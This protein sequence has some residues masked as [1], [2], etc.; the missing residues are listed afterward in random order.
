L[1]GVKPFTLGLYADLLRTITQRYHLDLTTCTLEELQSKLADIETGH[2][3]TYYRELVSCVKICL[4]HL[5]RR[6]LYDEIANPRLPNRAEIIKDKLLTD[7]EIR[8]LIRKAPSLADRLVIELFNET[9]ARRGEL[10]NL[11]IKSVQFDKYGAILTLTG[12]SGTRRR[13]VYNA[14]PDLRQYIN[15]HPNRKNPEAPLLLSRWNTPYHASGFYERIRLL[16]REILGRSIHP[17][18]FRHSTATRD[19]SMFT[20]REM[21]SLMGWSSAAMVGVYSHLSM[22]D[23]EN[24][25]LVLHGLKRK[26]ILRP[27]AGVQRCPKCRSDNAPIATYCQECGSVLSK[28]TGQLD[29]ESKQTIE[30][31]QAQIDEL[32]KGRG[33]A[34]ED[35]KALVEE[36][37]KTR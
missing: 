30:S 16:G 32:R 21:M 10:L 24:K 17:H 19:A 26:E 20:D 25:D 12:K 15:N 28:Q 34:K 27:I 7:Q 23:V 35:I 29:S 18:Q 6:D 11:K 31:M 5:K 9:G 37:L 8:Q 33:F 2:K 22:R 1:R 14:V 36:Y 4:K 3:P 13:R